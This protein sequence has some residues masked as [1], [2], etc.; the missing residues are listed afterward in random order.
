MSNTVTAEMTAPKDV[1][2]VVDLPLDQEIE[3]LPFFIDGYLK[4]NKDGLEKMKEKGW[5][6]LTTDRM[7]DYRSNWDTWFG[8][9]EFVQ[10][11]LD[12]AGEVDIT[13][14]ADKNITYIKDNGKGFLTKHLLLGQHKGLTNKEIHLSRGCFGEGMKLAALPFFRNGSKLFIRTVGLDIAF[15]MGPFDEHYVHYTF[16]RKNNH[17]AGTHIAISN[18]NGVE[19]KPRF[20]Q[21]LE[22]SKTLISIKGVKSDYHPYEEGKVR[23]VLDMPGNFFVR[24]IWVQD[25]NE[26]KYNNAFFGYNLWFDNTRDVLDP[27]RTSIKARDFVTYEFEH[28]LGCKDVDFLEKYFRRISQPDEKNGIT[29]PRFSFEHSYIRGEYYNLNKE[30]CEVILKAIKRVFGDREFTWSQKYE[31]EKALEHLGILDLTGKLPN[32]MRPLHSHKLIH[33]AAEWIMLRDLKHTCTITEDMVKTQFGATE[34][35]AFGTVLKALTEITQIYASSQSKV[36][37]FWSIKPSVE[38]DR[39][40]GFYTHFER[41]ISVKIDQLRSF[42]A[43]MSTFIHELGHALSRG[44]EDLTEAFEKALVESGFYV[45]E[46]FMKRPEEFKKVKE[47]ITKLSHLDWTKL[48]LD[49]SNS[50]IT[51]PEALTKDKK[52]EDPPF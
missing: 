36:C 23:Q 20:A 3:N 10:N 22:K 32:L 25:L 35:E 44:A 19:L 1:I 15:A 52:P 9:R 6:W 29:D 4:V 48:K 46:Y 18:F 51:L 43:V 38:V 13:H 12:E 30:Q 2:E 24:D 39:V 42:H 33:S 47:A 40:G 17:K 31:E 8:T 16:K 11:S 7:I 50:K 14:D 28:I 34:G 5:D 41:L 27:D 37:F 49:M 45:N 26:R 21:F